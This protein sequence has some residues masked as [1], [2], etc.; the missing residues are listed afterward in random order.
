MTD[1]EPSV[2]KK[3][4]H[5]PWIRL[6]GSAA[7]SENPAGKPVGWYLERNGSA[8]AVQEGGYAAR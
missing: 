7:A 6:D 1:V 3:V 5:V 2:T 8:K 4:R